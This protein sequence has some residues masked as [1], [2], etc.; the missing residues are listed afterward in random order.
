M[1]ILIVEDD[2]DFR[3]LC[4]KALHAE[5]HEVYEAASGL[6]ALN[7]LEKKFQPDLILLDLFMPDMNGEEFMRSLRI[8]NEWK[9]IGVVLVS[10]N[11]SLRF[12]ARELDADGILPKPF[13]LDALY[14]TVNRAAARS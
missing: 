1:K 11:D 3:R 6:E 13:N 12:K 7:L 2:S 9:N 5:A 4:A 10:G 8:R 14:E